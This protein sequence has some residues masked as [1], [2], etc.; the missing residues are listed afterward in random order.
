MMSLGWLILDQRKK[1]A[2][3]I[4]LLVMEYEW[5]SAVCFEVFI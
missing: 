3:I 2:Q 1:N 4:S 5:E